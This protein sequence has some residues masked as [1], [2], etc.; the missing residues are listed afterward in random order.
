[1]D[2]GDAQAAGGME[3]DAQQDVSEE[4]SSSWDDL[5]DTTQQ[6]RQ[7]T[8]PRFGSKS[9]RRRAALQSGGT[10]EE[11]DGSTGHEDANSMQGSFRDQD[12]TQGDEDS[13]LEEG[14]D[15]GEHDRLWT[16]AGDPLD[17]P[18]CKGQQP[19]GDRMDYELYDPGYMQY[20]NF[21]S[22]CRLLSRPPTLFRSD[23]ER[24]LFAAQNPSYS[25]AKVSDFRL[26]TASDAQLCLEHC[27][28]AA[29]PQIL[30]DVLD[31]PEGE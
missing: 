28:G 14:D 17:P 7:Q 8:E 27:F 18:S 21:A 23:N 1:M 19:E 13:V 31:I 11:M 3:L 26:L 29:D 5:G 24:P 4:W 30:V 9:A 10:D 25:I 16:E 6:S 2:W 20:N 22:D 12:G 15:D